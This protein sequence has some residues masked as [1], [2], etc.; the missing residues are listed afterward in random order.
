MK[1]PR[2]GNI[3][4]LRGEKLVVLPAAPRD[5]GVGASTC[6]ANSRL[7][8]RPVR[9]RSI[10]GDVGI[11][12]RLERGLRWRSAGEHPPPEACCEARDP[13]RRCCSA[14]QP[15]RPYREEAGCTSRRVR[16]GVKDAPE[17]TDEPF[18]PRE[19]ARRLT[20]TAPPFGSGSV[21]HRLKM[22]ASPNVPSERPGVRRIERVRTVLDQEQVVLSAELHDRRQVRLRQ[23]EVVRHQ[24]L[25]AFARR[26]PAGDRRS[27]LGPIRRHDR[28]EPWQSL[29]TASSSAPQL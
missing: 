20:S 5:L 12:G 26:W 16:R 2:P 29:R 28:S 11:R 10:E 22:P 3:T 19:A 21:F 18:R 15:A 23:P 9:R 13:E 14:T 6:N 24:I 17:G 7:A 25:L 1:K 8:H 27:R 4:E